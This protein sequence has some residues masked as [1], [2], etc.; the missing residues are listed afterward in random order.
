MTHNHMEMDMDMGSSTTSSMTMASTGGSMSGMTM[1]FT[2]SQSSTLFSSDWVPQST[3]AYAGT[4][5]FL[6]ALA[7]IYRS[8]ISFKAVVEKRW[9]DRDVQRRYITVA[10]QTPD[11]ER[12]QDRQDSKEG[13]LL[14]T[15]GVAENVRV[16]KN[17]SRPIRPW[18]LS[19][20]LPR[21]CLVVVIDVGR[22][23]YERGLFPIYT[24]GNIPRRANSRT[25]Y[26]GRGA[27]N[28]FHRAY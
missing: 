12:F 20:D 21:A 25:V 1:A 10:G 11:A 16:V 13:L 5:I 28:K 27:L 4:C 3:G 19:V 26:S 15:N 2:N 7:L 6:I 18:R 17:S 23:D 22:H 9:H 24:G 8:L 14:S